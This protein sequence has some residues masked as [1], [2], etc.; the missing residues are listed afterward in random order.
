MEKCGAEK[1][2]RTKTLHSSSLSKKAFS[3]EGGWKS[4]LRTVRGVELGASGTGTLDAG[5][6]DTQQEQCAPHEAAQALFDVTGISA[7]AWPGNTT[8]LIVR[9]ISHRAAT[10]IMFFTCFI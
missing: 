8:R 6:F 10:S 5:A 2:D 7:K 3:N 4:L 1:S 9:T